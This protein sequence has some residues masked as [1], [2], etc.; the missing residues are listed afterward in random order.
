MQVLNKFIFTLVLL[1]MGVGQFSYGFESTSGFDLEKPTSNQTPFALE[2]SNDKA[3]PLE[4]V[5]LALPEISSFT[6]ENSNLNPSDFFASNGVGFFKIS[7]EVDLN[8]LSYSAL[9]TPALNR[10][11]LIFPFHLFP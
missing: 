4:Q 5:T 10:L 1:L 8:Y 9:I 6:V 2:S 11:T 7:S 3:I